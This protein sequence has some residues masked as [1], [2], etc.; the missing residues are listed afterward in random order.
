MVTSAALTGWCQKS[1]I[2]EAADNRTIATEPTIMRARAEVVM[3][4]CPPG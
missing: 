2:M 3:P 4:A 1:H